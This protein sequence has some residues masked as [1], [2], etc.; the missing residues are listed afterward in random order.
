MNIVGRAD[1]WFRFRAQ[2]LLNWLGRKFGITRKPIL[3]NSLIALA[4]SWA[5]FCSSER[6]WFMISLDV[7]TLIINL[8]LGASFIY[9]ID[10]RHG[11]EA[12]WERGKW[13]RTMWIIGLP[14]QLALVAIVIVGAIIVATMR[15]FELSVAY[16]AFLISQFL[17]FWVA[18]CVEAPPKELKQQKVLAYNRG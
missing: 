13:Y 17:L 5:W 2:D 3:I 6:N 11:E 18:A 7:L 12:N 9:N 10:K 15:D 4:V 1:W 8:L 16:P 14:L